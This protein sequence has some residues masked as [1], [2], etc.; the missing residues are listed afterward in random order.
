M[1]DQIFMNIAKECAKSSKCISLHVGAVLVKDG[2]IIS[3]GYNG[4]PAGHTNCCDGFGV[5]FSRK[6]HADWSAKFE[7]HAEMNAL[8]HCPV[9]TYGATCY[10]TMAPCFNCLKHLAAAGVERVVY[11]GTRVRKHDGG[12]LDRITFASSNGIIMEPVGSGCSVF[13]EVVTIPL[14]VPST[15]GLIETTESC[16][17]K[18]KTQ[19][20][21][22]LQA[23]IG[24][25]QN[26]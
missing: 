6:A 3:T 16:L 22:Q 18:G 4:T 10:V 8:L 17:E 12:L 25:S 5:E 20:R 11:G 7:I 9:S 2:R 14:D 23:D 21:N 1:H 24:D 26:E 15:S 13:K 19:S